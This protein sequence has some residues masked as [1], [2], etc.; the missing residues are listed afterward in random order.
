LEPCGVEVGFVEVQQAVDQKRVIARE[1]GDV[2]GALT[3]IA[4][5]TAVLP[6]LLADEARGPL[7]RLE[8]SA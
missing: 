2:A 3:V 8:K 6:Q 7:R 4:E 1:T 5:Q